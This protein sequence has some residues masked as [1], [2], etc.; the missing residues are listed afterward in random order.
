MIPVA[1]NKEGT[2]WHTN[3]HLL[4]QL[5]AEMQTL[6]YIS[7]IIT[8]A[9]EDIAPS[10]E[11]IEEIKW[12]QRG[13][14]AGFQHALGSDVF[15]TW[16]NDVLPGKVFNICPCFWLREKLS[17]S[18]RSGVRCGGGEV[19]GGWPL[20][21]VIKRE[22]ITG[23][24]VLYEADREESESKEMTLKAHSQNEREARLPLERAL[25]LT[26]FYYSP[27]SICKYSMSSHNSSFYFTW[28]YF[29]HCY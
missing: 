18:K 8:Q 29:V 5:C 23:S 10:M 9:Q 28:S 19:K 24:C 27:I 2:H 7:N 25:R 26:L 11:G 6:L 16:G 15:P 4:T 13:R 22:W 21:A 3:T 12:L 20:L 17:I 14:S 1:P